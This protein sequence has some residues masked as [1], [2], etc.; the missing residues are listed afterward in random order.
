MAKI[1]LSDENI[2]LIKPPIW[3]V[4][5]NIPDNYAVEVRNGFAL[6]TEADEEQEKLCNEV[7]HI[8]MKTAL[9]NIPKRQKKNNSHTRYT[10]LGNRETT[11]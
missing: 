4:L 8:V 6:L 3:Y 9:S 10:C 1:K 2:K 11:G 5:T 7:K